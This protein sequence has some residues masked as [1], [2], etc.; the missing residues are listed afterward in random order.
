MHS[1]VVLRIRMSLVRSEAEPPCRF[2]IV[3]GDPTAVRIELTDGK[4]R[5]YMA[6]VRSKAVPPY[7]FCV[8]LGN[9]RTV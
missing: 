2:Y 3:L 6:L 5:L 7:R 8:V 9:P 1:E 4:P